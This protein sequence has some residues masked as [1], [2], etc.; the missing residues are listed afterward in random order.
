MKAVVA[1]L[2]GWIIALSVAAQAQAEGCKDQT[3]TLK[4]SALEEFE[5]AKK[6][7]ADMMPDPGGYMAEVKRCVGN[8]S[9]WT[10]SIGFKMPSV[11]QI[12]SNMCQQIRSQVEIPQFD[13]N[14][15]KTIGQG[16]KRARYEVSD[17]DAELVFREIWDDVWSQQ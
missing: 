2:I 6:D 7:Y 13:F 12:L 11:D 3:D 4:Q 5:K 1:I 9:D 16:N 17:E 15:E 8:L 14:V 10:A